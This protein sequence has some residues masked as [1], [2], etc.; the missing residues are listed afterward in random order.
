VFN[1]QKG[2]AAGRIKPPGGV[3]ITI[4]RWAG[5]VTQPGTHAPETET[6]W[7]ESGVSR[8]FD[9]LIGNLLNI[10]VQMSND[11]FPNQARALLVKSL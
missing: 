10:D 1:T 5:T 6:R 2:Q 8:E 3:R 9:K 4:G 11:L 7:P